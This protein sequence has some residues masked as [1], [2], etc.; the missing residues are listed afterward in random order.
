[1]KSLLSVAALG[2][3]LCAG[4]IFAQASSDRSQIVN[5]ADLDL[6]TEAGRAALDRRISSAV[7]E[8]CGTASDANLR[9]Q[10]AVRRCRTLTAK[11]VTASKSQAIASAAHSSSTAF[12]AKK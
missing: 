4:P 10:N 2:A 1:M 9:G 3:A 11:L 6:R 5:Y 8:T 12:A 7:R